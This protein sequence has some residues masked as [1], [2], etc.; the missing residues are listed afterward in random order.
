MQTALVGLIMTISQPGVKAGSWRV[1]ETH[2]RRALDTHGY[3]CPDF[4][5]TG[6]TAMSRTVGFTASIGAQMLPTG[7][8]EG[9]GLLSPVHDV[10]WGPFEAQLAKRDIHVTDGF[11]EG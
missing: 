3:G 1:F 9:R 11:N 7:A 8:I 6:L 10:P 4:S 2:R 5:E